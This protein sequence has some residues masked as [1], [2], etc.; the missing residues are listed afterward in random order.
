MDSWPNLYYRRLAV[1][2]LRLF[3]YVICLNFALSGA[4]HASS[5]TNSAAI[6]SAHVL[7]SEAGEEILKAGGNAFDA[8]IAVSA[9][10]G[11]V[12]PFNSGLGGGGFFL[13]YRASDKKLTMLD[14]RERAPYSAHRNMFLNANGIP[15][16]RAS[17]DGPLAAAI[18][19]LPA[20][21]AWLARR[22]GALPFSQ[23]LEPAEKLARAGFSVDEEYVRLAKSR[24]SVLQK[25]PTSSEQFLNQNELPEPGI[26][27]KQPRLA[28][29]LKSLG[30]DG[31]LGFYQG[32]IAKQLVHAVNAGGGR[33]T[34]A[35]LRQYRVKERA[36][37]VISYRGAKI[38]TASL[39]SSGGLVMAQSLNILEHVDYA[40]APLEQKMHYVAEAL[41]RAYHDRF[42]YMGDE[43]FVPVPQ[44]RLSSKPYAAWR[45]ASVLADDASSNETLS[46][47]YIEGKNTTHFSIV[48]KYGN[49]VAATLSINTPFGSGFVA[50][51]SGVL[52]NNEM[53]DF[54]ISPGVANS[55][56][57][58]GGEAN[59]I[60]P[61]KRP[62][63]SMSPTFVEDDRGILILGTPGGSRII[64][65][66]L[67]AILDY[68]H[69]PNANLQRML[70]APRY[71]HQF[72]PNRIELEPNGFSKEIR[73]ELELKGHEL[74]ITPRSWG[75]MQ[76]IFI[77]KQTAQLSAA[78]DPRGNGRGKILY[79]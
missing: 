30:R 21:L 50:G 75:N 34:L 12:E 14:A 17:L 33:W 69:N 4:T 28:Q 23:A 20:G 10:L 7:A 64:S 56:G 73:D 68:V 25:Y 51:A 71:H 77:D 42:R 32:R 6:A 67:L 3:T 78:S 79:H 37:T 65:M 45:A 49:R 76:A 66:V 55:Y 29:T 36:P 43:D 53:D 15:I 70:S 16:P 47:P 9:V 54:S 1:L 19:G 40:A 44:A 2:F 57:L 31:G 13:L 24:L 39:P 27:I 8:A 38:I 22:Y 46:A 58:T 18:P 74:V 72:V 52:L 61:G 48:D 26:I 60:A 41:R 5:A 35:D 63:S 11:V 59:A 62:L